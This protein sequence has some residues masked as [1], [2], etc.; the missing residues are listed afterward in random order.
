MA[1]D[2]YTKEEFYNILN[3]FRKASYPQKVSFMKETWGNITTETTFHYQNGCCITIGFDN[4]GKYFYDFSCAEANFDEMSENLPEYLDAILNLDEKSL[5]EKYPE[6]I[7]LDIIDNLQ[8]ELIEVS[9]ED[10]SE[11]ISKEDVTYD[12]E[13]SPDYINA[14]NGIKIERKK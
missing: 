2:K 10:A 13:A 12:I 8:D 5:Q 9:A 4:S 14:Y 3:F 1:F 7:E 6:L 11:I